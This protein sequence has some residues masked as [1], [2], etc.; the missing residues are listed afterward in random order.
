[1]CLS[2]ILSNLFEALIPDQGEFPLLIQP[3]DLHQHPYIPEALHKSFHDLFIGRL[4]VLYKLRVEHI[5]SSK[6]GTVRINPTSIVLILRRRGI[7]HI[8]TSIDALTHLIPTMVYLTEIPTDGADE[9]CRLSN[10]QIG[11][12][13]L[14]C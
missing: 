4:I 9:S 3:T 5:S 11:M 6:K 8:S 10:L 12:V 7:R 14:T 2:E 1:M 13:R